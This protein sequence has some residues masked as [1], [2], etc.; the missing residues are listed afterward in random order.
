MVK[1]KGNDL[2]EHTIREQLEGNI[3]RCTGYHNIVK[4]IQ[5]GAA[6]D[7]RHVKRVGRVRSRARPSNQ[8]GA[9]SKSFRCTILTITDRPLS[10]P[11]PP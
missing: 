7:E 4:A 8:R 6:G 1:R 2:D 5:A 10:T 9:Q 3:C 11:P